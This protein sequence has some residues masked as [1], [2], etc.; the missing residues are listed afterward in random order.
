RGVTLGILKSGME[1][2]PGTVLM[3][4]PPSH[5]RHRGL[6]A[7]MFTPKRVSALEPE[8]RTLCVELLDPMVGSGGFDLAEV[9]AM[10]VPM[11][12][13][14]KLIG[15]PESDQEFIRDRVDESNPDKRLGDELLSGAIFADYIE[16]RRD[17][18]SDDIMTQLMYAEFE[19]ETG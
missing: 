19:D 11:R 6:L 3:E 13:I 12:V 18:P 2:P 17:H 14:G 10:Q 15:I 7:R 4:D 9:L 16:W 8:I 1:I 5:P